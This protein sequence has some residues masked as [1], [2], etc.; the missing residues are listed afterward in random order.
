MLYNL[1]LVSVLFKFHPYMQRFFIFKIFN[2]VA[3][4]FSVPQAKT[5]I[6][7]GKTVR[8]F[9]TAALAVKYFRF[10]RGA[11]CTPLLVVEDQMMRSAITL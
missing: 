8:Q 5:I 2:L 3:F 6:M 10:F 9:N 7:N 4:I 1:Y 11:S